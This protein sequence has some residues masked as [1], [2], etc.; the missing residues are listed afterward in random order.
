M[1]KGVI[2]MLKRK[3]MIYTRFERFWHWTQA[4]LIILLLI[5]GFGLHGFYSLFGFWAAVTIHT[6]AALALIVLWIFAIFWHLTTGQWRHYL[7]T[8]KG[9]FA[10]ARYYAYGIFRGEPHPYRKTFRR[11]HNPLQALSYLALKV[12]IFPAVWI[13]GLAYLLYGSWDHYAF[14]LLGLKITALVHTAA[15]FATLIFVIAHVYLTTTGHTIFTHIRSMI[16]GY[17]TVEL[18]EAEAAVLAEHEQQ[19]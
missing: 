18:T 12:V 13:S 15:A 4:G 7:P 1:G 17:E 9:L 2:L 3:I 19:P 8:T 11:K 6:G 5:T 10:V 14:S 16:T